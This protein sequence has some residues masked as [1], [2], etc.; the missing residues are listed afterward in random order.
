MKLALRLLAVLGVLLLLGIGALAVLLPRALESEA[1][2]RRIDAAARQAL[3]RELRYDALE[4][5]LFPPSLRMESPRLVDATPEEVPL[6]AKRVALRVALLPLL[7]RTVV[8]DSLRID[9]ATLRLVRTEQGTALAASPVVSRA[10][11]QADAAAGATV[12]PES[13]PDAASPVALAVREIALRDASLVLEDRTVKPA[14]TWTLRKIDATAHGESLDQRV[15]IEAALEIASGG[16]VAVRGH[17]VPA[18]DLDLDISLDGVALAAFRPYAGQA[19][20]DG[21][22]A[23][24]VHVGGPSARPNAVSADLGIRAARFELED[25]GVA[26]DIAAKINLRDPF[27]R[28]AGDFSL[29]AGAA[30][31]HYG[32]AFSKPPDTPATLTGVITCSPG[33]ALGIDDLHLRIRDLEATGKARTQPLRVELSTQSLDLRGIETL[34]PPLATTRPEGRIR[35]ESLRYSGAPAALVGTIHLEDVKL[36]PTDGVPITLRG[37]L[38]AEG[39]RLRSQGLELVAAGQRAAADLSVRDLFGVPSYEIAIAADGADANA[40]TTA[41]AHKPDVLFG[42]LALHGAL[43]GSFEPGRTLLSSLG[44]ELQSNITNGRLVGV[45]LLEATFRRVGAAGKLG[46]LAL[47][48]GRL[49]GGRDVQRFYADAFD[50]IEAKLSIADGVVRAEPLTLRYPSYSAHLTG[51]IDLENL[52]LDMRGLLTILEV[53]D[54][55]IAKQLGAVNYKATARSIPLASVRGSLNAPV[56]QIGGNQIVEFVSHYASALYGGRLRGELDK[57]LGEGAG[58]AVEGALKGILGEKP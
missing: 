34:V 9:G 4:V 12:A 19:S 37:A 52:S 32:G 15:E 58:E 54:A 18:G 24:R 42:P 36:T 10:A 6:A 22:L 57:K 13:A 40:L 48:A 7:A 41:I 11:P 38:L 44:G 47:D 46:T 33:G 16:R 30:E 55:S 45:S 26:G 49:F 2:R 5:G 14:L 31:L 20:L 23:G 27:T 51:S 28:A 1:V 50:A 35:V 3:G 8:I 39:T 53:V 43:R 25:I 56:V 21:V 17:A 29:D